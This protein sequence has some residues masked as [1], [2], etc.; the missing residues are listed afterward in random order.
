MNPLLTALVAAGLLSPDDAARLD[1]QLDS[2]A[3]R[4]WAEQQMLLAFQVGLSGQRDRLVDAVRAS[5]G[6]L[7]LA[8]QS[9]LWAGENDKLWASVRSTLLDI[10]SERATVAAIEA[11]A[12]DDMWN[13]VNDR[14][15][16]WAENYYTSPA[17]ANVGSIPNL[18]QTSR[19]RVGQAIADWQRGVLPQVG[20]AEGLPLLIRDLESTLGRARAEMIAVTETTRIFTEGLR[21]AEAENPFMTQWEWLTAEDEM[22]CPLC[23]P[24]A[25]TRI[26]KTANGF[27]TE[28]DGLVGFPPIH[29]RCR[30]QIIALTDAAAEGVPEGAREAVTVT[31]VAE[32]AE[33]VAQTGLRPTGTPVSS[34]LTVAKGKAKDK[35][36]IAL[37][38]IDSVHGD[39]T[40]RPI[41]IN[42]RKSKTTWGQY[43]YRQMR[44]RSIPVEIN[45]NPTEGNHAATT[46]AHE[47]GHYL[48][49]QSL[50]IT[51]VLP[52]DKITPEIQAWRKTIADSEAVKTLQDWRSKGHEI[53][54]TDPN[55]GQERTGKVDATYIKYMLRHDELWARSYAQYIAT[56]SG[57]PTMLAE[58]SAIRSSP[59]G[60]TQWADGDF[61]PIAEAID[62]ILRAAGWLQ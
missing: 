61:V 20:S 17:A 39:G 10:A 45:I 47:V 37:S 21:A 25:G 51:Q 42:Q 58:I 5:D 52:T 53:T 14:M 50:R 30:C 40:L 41:P 18:N 62:E 15:V 11:G 3:A 29:V 4:E 36:E 55:T 2:Q 57:N 24:R 26:A 23:G 12:D 56:R 27:A 44:D 49:D 43:K 35:I 46:M 32:P 8:Q 19:Q 34:A 31:P 13:L 48:D 16:D 1:R 28:T 33:E 54:I 7:T 60:V 22:V 9:R 59:Y 6:L 38:A